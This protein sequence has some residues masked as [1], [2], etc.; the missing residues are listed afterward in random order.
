MLFSVCVTQELINYDNINLKNKHRDRVRNEIN[1]LFF[2]IIK[3]MKFHF[4]F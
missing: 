2:I 1:F 4:F 3:K